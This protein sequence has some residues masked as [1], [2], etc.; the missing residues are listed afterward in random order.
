VLFERIA[1]KTGQSKQVILNELEA[2][3]EYIKKIVEKGVRDQREVAEMILAYYSN[4]QEIKR[5][6]E[7]SSKLLPTTSSQEDKIPEEEDTQENEL[8]LDF[9]DLPELDF[10]TTKDTE[11]DSNTEG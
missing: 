9:L 2:R 8:D 7:K 10:Q 1:E 4:R 11:D 5:K 6:S 3:T